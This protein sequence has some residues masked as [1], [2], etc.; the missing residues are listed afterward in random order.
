MGKFDIVKSHAATLNIRVIGLETPQ[1]I[2]TDELEGGAD[3]P[4]S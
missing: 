3:V 4:P 2:D 1:L